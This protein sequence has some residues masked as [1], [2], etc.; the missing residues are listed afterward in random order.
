MENKEKYTS[1]LYIIKHFL[2]L[3]HGIS[4]TYIPTLFF[5]SLF[6]A[7]VPFLNI[8]MPKY[9]IDELLGARRIKVLILLVLLTVI[10][11]GV[12]NLINRVLDKKCNIKNEEVVA[13]FDLLIGKK[14]M[15]LDFENIE[16][17]E[18]LN[19]KERALFPIRNQGAIWQLTYNISKG[20]TE[21]LKI[22]GLI[23]VIL[24]LDWIIIALIILIVLLSSFMYKKSQ[25]L[26]HKFFDSLIPL[27][28]EFGYY[29]NTINDF[30]AGKDIRLYNVAPLFVKKLDEFN[31]NSTN[32]FIKMFSKLGVYEGLNEIVLQ[33][34]MVIVYGY[35]TYKVL[36]NSIGIGDFTM[37]TNAAIN[38]SKSI[39][40]LFGSYVTI[41]QMC[42]YLQAFMEFENIESKHTKE[43]KKI[44]NLEKVNIEFKN[45][46]FKYPRSK[47]FTLKNVSIKINEGE[48][49]SV[50][51][52]NGA[53]KT[54]FIKLLARLYEPTEGEILLNGVNI[55]EYDY[56]EYMKL[57]S[58]VFQDFKL[59]S[60]SIKENI[61][62]NDFNK[63]KDEEIE[64]VLIKSGFGK[65]L[66]KLPKGINT[67]IYKNFDEGGIE[68]SGGQAQ[69]LAIA[70]AVYKNAPIVIL[71]EPTAALDPKAEYEIYS[72][73]NELIGKKTTI[74]I[75][76]RLSSCRFCDNIAVFQK[77]KL[78]Q[79]GTHDELVK[80]KGNEYE[81]MYSAQA[82][83]YI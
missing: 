56:D 76:H 28:R 52:L 47:E 57:L 42:R 69:K 19:L 32:A 17:P 82:Q 66:E 11:N 70:R 50:V 81:T 26:Q 75:S 6:A 80:D 9:I 65:D 34:Q 38:F 24:T 2:N 13:G 27:N 62:L 79:Y 30:S 78:I 48:K 36:I 21:I 53:G 51:G 58:V 15:D 54:T 67:P 83:Y 46:S 73:F 20:L 64:E 61:A 49:L 4:K 77:G 35:I 29:I 16:D 1:D 22:I 71:D 33:L 23:G 40:N 45:V 60:F 59:M 37:Y 74:Y 31:I 55:N 12:L 7:A 5:S 25:R 18:I 44:G 39:S 63:V 10:G 8:I 43:G 14:V 72:K 3:A 68:F 41:R